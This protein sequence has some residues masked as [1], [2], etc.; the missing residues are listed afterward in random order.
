MSVD[1]SILW[2]RFFQKIIIP[3]IF[4]RQNKSSLK[5]TLKFNFNHHFVMIERGAGGGAQK[6]RQLKFNFNHHFQCSFN[7]NGFNSSF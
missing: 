6:S 5:I 7:L 4:L 3:S 1:R 2:P